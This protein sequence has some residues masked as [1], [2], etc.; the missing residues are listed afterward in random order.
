MLLADFYSMMPDKKAALWYPMVGVS[1]DI[2]KLRA[3]LF[4]R[5]NDAA[6]WD[7]SERLRRDWVISKTVLDIAK[8]I[9]I[10]HRSCPTALVEATSCHAIRPLIT[11]CPSTAITNSQ[12]IP[13][14]SELSIRAT[15]SQATPLPLRRHVRFHTPLPLRRKLIMPGPRVFSGSAARTLS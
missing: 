8:S 4:C 1:P 2:E 5:Q 3:K 6:V 13:F 10:H 7:K 15:S 11:P 9:Y 14:V 12:D